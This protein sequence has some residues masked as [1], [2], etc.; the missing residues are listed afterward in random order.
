MAKL[1]ILTLLCATILMIGC[2]KDFNS[3][4]TISNIDT[5]LTE[6]LE[7]WEISKTVCDF[8][9]NPRDIFFINSDIGFMVAFNGCI[10]KTINAGKSWHKQNS[11]TTLHLYS[12]FFLNENI[13][14]VS[15]RA[16]NDLSDDGGKGSVLLRTTNG[17]ETWTKKNFEDYVDMKCLHF[18]NESQGLAII[19]TPDIPNSRDYYISKTSD[20]GDN[21]EF[22]DLPIRP[23]FGKYYCV[24]NVVFIAG[25]NQNIFKSTDYGVS[26]VT[27]NTPIPA[28]QNVMNIYFYNQNIGY[29]D[30][31]NLY[32][33]INGGLNWKTVDVPFSFFDDFH[34]YNEM[35]G[36]NTDSVFAYEGDCEV[37][38]G[39]RSYQTYDGGESWHKSKLVD[40]LCFGRSYFP[41]RDLGYSFLNTEFY[42]IKKK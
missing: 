12:V 42:T 33:T 16:S 10:Y 34:F 23:V 18:F 35:D 19:Y 7:G 5:V 36:F 31:T 38:K 25:E 39:I 26:W 29:L 8:D 41:Q 20:G 30:G 4:D 28:S 1:R 22:I 14:F 6:F 32:K 40:T 11:G 37:F 9:L 13:G 3:N 27:L 17:G 21:W 2:E 15:G 24:D